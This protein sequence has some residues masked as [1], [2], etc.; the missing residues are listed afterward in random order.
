MGWSYISIPKPLQFR[1]VYVIPSHTLH[2]M[3]LLIHM[4]RLKL[5]HVSKKGQ[6]KSPY[7]ACRIH[8]SH[9]Y[10]IYKS[11]MS[12]STSKSGFSLTISVGHYCDVIMSAM[13]SQ[14][15]S[16]TIVSTAYSDADQRKH[17][18]SASLAFVPHKWSVTR[19]MFPFDDVIVV[20]PDE[21]QS[22]ATVDVN[23]LCIAHTENRLTVLMTSC[24]GIICLLKLFRG[25]VR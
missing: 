8:I 22:W 23:R 10:D 20:K 9:Y 3:W 15:T 14:I 4:L 25:I 12:L 16:L 1:N 21:A 11:M 5:I 13:A 19:K 18:S 7:E 2:A 6:P 17:Q 24:H